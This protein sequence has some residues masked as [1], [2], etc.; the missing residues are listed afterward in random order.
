[1]KP[2]EDPHVVDLRRYRQAA[3]RKA[4]A[5]P[6]AQEPLLGARPRAGLILTLVVLVLLALWILPMLV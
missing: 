5:K 3:Q 1:M 2:D 6:P 4:A